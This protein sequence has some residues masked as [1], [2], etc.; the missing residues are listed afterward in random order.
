MR[1][2]INIK[3][4]FPVEI[5]FSEPIYKRDILFFGQMTFSTLTPK[6]KRNNQILTPYWPKDQFSAPFA[7]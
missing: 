5:D 3:I 6:S 1:A 7:L 2:L 4:D